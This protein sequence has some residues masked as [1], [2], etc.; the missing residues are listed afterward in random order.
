MELELED[1]K[2]YEGRYKINKA[3]QVWSVK[4]QKFLK[5]GSSTDGYYMVGLTKENK[6]KQKTFKV[7]RLLALQF[8]PNPL[9]LPAVDH[10]DINKTNNSLDNLRWVSHRTNQLNKTIK[11]NTG[12]Q[13]ISLTNSNTYQVKIM[14]DKKR[15]SKTFNTMDEAKTYRDTFI[16]DNNLF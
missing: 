16:R 5:P 10:I 7:H 12:E 6:Q 1:L 8:L 14:L 4:Y 13:N 3:G 9:G 11:S 15:H 2:G